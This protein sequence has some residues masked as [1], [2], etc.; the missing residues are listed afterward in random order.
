MRSEPTSWSRSAA[1][2]VLALAALFV[3]PHLASAQERPFSDFL[4]QHAPKTRTVASENDAN[5]VFLKTFGASLEVPNHLF[6]T[7]RNR[8]Q[9]PLPH[10]LTTHL[11][12]FVANLTTWQLTSDLLKTLDQGATMQSILESRQQQLAW[13]AQTKTQLALPGILRLVTTIAQLQPEA[14]LTPPPAAPYARF[15]QYLHEQ[16]PDW[17]GTPNSW[18]TVA[19]TRGPSGVRERLHEY[20][21][22]SSTPRDPNQQETDPTPYINRFLQQYVLP[23]TKVY[24]Q[25]ALLQ[26]RAESEQGAWTHWQAIQQWSEANKN[27]KGLW[28]LCGT[29][30]WLIHNHQDHGDHKTV[31]VYPPPSEYHRMD[32][33]PAKIQVQGDTVY[34]RWEFPRGIVQEESLLLTEKDRLLSGTFVNNLGP[35]GNITGRRLK[36]CQG[37]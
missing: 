8:K 32:P 31:M 29:W 13:L 24:A 18:L 30:Q 6:Q 36:P 28:R 20:W 22:S 7:P 34:I 17:I 37:K 27:E 14:P 26:L 16:Y 5:A 9:P 21:T 10:G 35:N 15:T 2:G 33:Q 19:Q 11:S 23:T 4:I 25:A 3:F 12:P 1:I